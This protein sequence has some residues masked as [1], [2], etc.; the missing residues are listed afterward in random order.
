MN[1]LT[2]RILQHFPV[3]ERWLTRFFAIQEL[4]KFAVDDLTAMR[5][6]RRSLRAHEPPRDMPT[7]IVRGVTSPLDMLNIGPAIVLHQNKV[8][9]LP[10]GVDD[11]Y[12][13]AFGPF[14]TVA[15]AVAD[16]QL[17]R[18]RS[19]DNCHKVVLALHEVDDIPG[20]DRGP[21]E[22][23]RPPSD[24]LQVDE[25]QPQQPARPWVH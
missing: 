9:S 21:D 6:R 12:A 24:P 20:D 10:G 8:G 14:A 17:A 5:D 22:I 19:G 11:V 2:A 4:S 23:E 7:V 15:D 18:E 25:E 13:H 3:V 1:S 16:A